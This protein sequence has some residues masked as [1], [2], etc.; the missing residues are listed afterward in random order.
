MLWLVE[1]VSSCGLRA[2]G[3]KLTNP[4]ANQIQRNTAPTSRTNSY[5]GDKWLHLKISRQ[6]LILTSVHNKKPPLLIKQGLEQGHNTY[7][8]KEWMPTYHT[9]TY[10][11]EHFLPPLFRGRCISGCN[12]T[13]ASLWKGHRPQFLVFFPFFFLRK[14]LFWFSS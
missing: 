12:L 14:I 11:F 4:L 3:S 10:T 7:Q 6:T 5:I 8:Q 1:F 2:L 13:K 9:A